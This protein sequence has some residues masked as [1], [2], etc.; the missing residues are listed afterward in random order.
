MDMLHVIGSH[1]KKINVLVDDVNAKESD[2]VIITFE[3]ETRA[4]SFEY[5]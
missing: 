5:I 3:I 1:L 2:L 4:L